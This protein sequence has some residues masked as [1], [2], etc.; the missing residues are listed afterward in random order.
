LKACIAR[1][2]TP[3]TIPHKIF[4]QNVLNH[5]FMK[6]V[7]LAGLAVALKNKKDTDSSFS[8]HWA[9]VS[10]W[11]PDVRYE[12]KDHH[13]AQLLIDAVDGVMPWIKVYW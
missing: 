8:A 3:E 9:L 10:E 11:K 13:S 6:L 4:L 1:Q 12:S 2:V 5:D 7:S